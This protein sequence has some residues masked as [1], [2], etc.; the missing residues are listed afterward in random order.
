MNHTWN[1][2]RTNIPWISFF[3]QISLQI[4]TGS[5]IVVISEFCLF[6]HLPLNKLDTSPFI[7]FAFML[8]NIILCRR[9]FEVFSKRDLCILMI[10]FF[11][12]NY[13]LAGFLHPT[14][15]KLIR[16]LCNSWQR[17][18]SEINKLLSSISKMNLIAFAFNNNFI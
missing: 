18:C 1:V 17:L 10:Y 12:M 8:E 9:R 11:I 5:Y 2:F 16:L 7:I 4:A 13:F 6:V 3:N 15:R 14:T